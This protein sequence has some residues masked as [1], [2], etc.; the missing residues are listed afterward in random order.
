MV[1]ADHSRRG[2]AWRTCWKAPDWSRE[3]RRWSTWIARWIAE[4][5]ATGSFGRGENSS[6]FRRRDSSTSQCDALDADRPG[7]SSKACQSGLRPRSRAPNA[8]PSPR[9]HSSRATVARS[10][11]PGASTANAFSR[12][13]PRPSKPRGAAHSRCQSSPIRTGRPLRP[14]AGPMTPSSSI[15]SMSRAARL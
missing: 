11:V 1:N 4:T 10:T 3:G 15:C 8:E 12:N 7:K 6:F 14:S 5:A 13:S 9:C 2:L